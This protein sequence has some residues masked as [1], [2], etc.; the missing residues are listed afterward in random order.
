MGTKAKNNG[1][2]ESPA[3]VH[4]V[5]AHAGALPPATFAERL[6]RLFANVYPPDSEPYTNEDVI[7]T[8][9]LRG[10]KL[11]A[12]YLS[13]LRTGQRQRPSKQKVEGIAGFFGVRT[14]YFTD[15]DESYRRAVEADLDGL[16]LARNPGVRLLMTAL[17]QLQPTVR[18]KVMAEAGL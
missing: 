16:E 10:T 7:H 9:A 5:S 17:T 1:R 8:L 13:Q 11:S 15:R 18:E 3:K 4:Q 2:S 6:N 12:P 14:D